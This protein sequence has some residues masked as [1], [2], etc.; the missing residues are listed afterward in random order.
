MRPIPMILITLA[1]LPMAAAQAIE[2]YPDPNTDLIPVTEFEGPALEFEFPGL[3]IGVAEYEE[4]PT[5]ASVF[6]F[7]DGV[8]AAVDVRG[9][10][11]GTILTESLRLGYEDAWIKAIALAGGSAYG[12]A[13]ATGAALE[14][15][16][17]SADPGFWTEVPGVPG[18]IVFDLGDKRYN[19]VTPDEQLGR[20]AIRSAR[21]GYFPLG[22]RGAGRFVMH[23]WYF[24]EPRFSGQGAAYGQYGDTRIVVFT[25]VNAMGAVIDRTG[26]AVR[27]GRPA[28]E[29]CPMASDMLAKTA[30]SLQTAADHGDGLTGNTTLTLVVTNRKL[31]FVEL[32]R[33]ATQVHT[34]M[35]RAIQP[36]H[37]LYDGDTLFAATTGTVEDDALSIDQLGVLASELAWDAVLASVPLLPEK[38]AA[39][40]EPKDP[41]Q[42]RQLTGV[43]EF[44]P[45]MQARVF[46][47]QEKLLIE[48]PSRASRYLAA[49]TRVQLIEAENGDFLLATDRSDLLRFTLNEQGAVSGLAINP[50]SWPVRARRID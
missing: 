27:C 42:W 34:S 46:V 26:R 15:K 17:H 24:G 21:P 40:A 28:T 39:L 8:M 10:S 43:Y 19:A 35:G 6:H 22:A 47:D 29:P 11:P 44:A 4:G 2:T 12:L 31:D 7:P 14:I 37:T 23:S 45:G 33:M 9:G 5:G 36:F 13:A 25:V 1:L 49:N 50:D 32:Q 3:L 38:P 48:A 41:A 16:T 30:Q 20:A 18:A